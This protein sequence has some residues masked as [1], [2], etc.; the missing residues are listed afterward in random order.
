M[1]LKEYWER[2]YEAYKLFLDNRIYLYS[3]DKYIS[4]F[5]EIYQKIYIYTTLSNKIYK[6]K[7]RDKLQDFFFSCKNSLI[8]ALDLTNINYIN[9]SKQILRS[10]IEA[11][12]RLSLSFSHYIEYRENKKRKIFNTTDSLKELKSMQYNHKVGKMTMFVKQYFSETPVSILF[13]KLYNL[14]SSLSSAVHVNDIKHF[15]P[16]KYLE[17]YTKIDESDIKNHLFQ[18]KTVINSILIIIYYF[19]FKLIDEDINISKANLNRIESSLSE[20]ELSTLDSIDQY[21]K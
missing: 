21:F 10:S 8:I 6:I 2:D 16:Y 12:F 4:D 20:A 11:F 18:I 15:S 1:Q 7:T 17:D 14:Y 3:Q 5:E 13:D 9:A 19:T